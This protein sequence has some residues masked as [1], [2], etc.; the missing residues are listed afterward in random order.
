[1]SLSTRGRE[2][3]KKGIEKVRAR[4]RKEKVGRRVEVGWKGEKEIWP[5][6]GRA[7]AGERE[8][9]GQRVR[10]GPGEGIGFLF[11]LI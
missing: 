7:A 9:L 1:M 8:K 6:S 4:R 5:V 11:L 2:D 10:E 3:K